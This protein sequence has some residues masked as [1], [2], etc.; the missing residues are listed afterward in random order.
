LR[1]AA[2]AYRNVQRHHLAFAAPEES[3][4]VY[5]KRTAGAAPSTSEALNDASQSQRE[6]LN[7]YI[8]DRGICSRRDADLWI[9]SGR[10]TVNDQPAAPGDLIAPSDQVRVDGELLA[11]HAKPKRVYIALNKP[12]GIECTT[13]LSVDGN[14]IDFVGHSERIFPIG[15][16]DKDS[17]GLILLTNDGDIVNRM[18]RKEYHHEKEYVVSVERKIALT[19]LQRMSQGL[20]I[21]RRM[22]RPCRTYKLGAQTFGIVLTEGMNRQIRRMADVLGHRVMRLTRI[23]MLN[24]SLGHLKLGKWRNLTPAEISELQKRLEAP[25]LPQSKQAA[26][27]LPKAIAEKAARSVRGKSSART[28]QSESQATPARVRQQ[29]LGKRLAT[30]STPRANA[31]RPQKPAQK[32]PSR[33]NKSRAAAARGAVRT[34]R[35][36]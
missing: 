26:Q 9:E 29:T 23:R 22:T 13:N 2:F 28:T 35:R 19:D 18:L 21:L 17:D 7:K 30:K 33:P 20:P 12:V 25:A 10:V 36:D 11:L 34:K 4:M 27:R 14:I 15:R 3:N 5:R 24:V 6:R 8:A 1:Q 16:L 32:N 31:A